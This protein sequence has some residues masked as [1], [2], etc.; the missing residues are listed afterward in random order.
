MFNIQKIIK[1]ILGRSWVGGKG[2]TKEEDKHTILHVGRLSVEFQFQHPSF[3]RRRG[4]QGLLFKV[5][6]ISSKHHLNN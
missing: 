1:W 4:W 5:Q 2:E 6:K 3:L